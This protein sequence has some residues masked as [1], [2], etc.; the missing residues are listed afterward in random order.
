M[1][2]E[3]V[4][5]VKLAGNEGVLAKRDILSMQ[6]SLLRTLKTL[7]NFSKTRSEEL[8]I[9]AKLFKTIKEFHSN[10]SK[11]ES[12]IPKLTTSPIKK[13]NKKDAEE[14]E[15]SDLNIQSSITEKQND[16]LES[17][18]RDIQEKLKALQR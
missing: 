7:R 1:K 4:R 9:K 14:K 16:D 12:N 5:Y 2:S 13:S 18:L 10:I 17:Q 6:M 15:F 11:I 8:K 3:E